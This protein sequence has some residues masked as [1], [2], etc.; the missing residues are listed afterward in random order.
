M[1]ECTQQHK[2]CCTEKVAIKQ[3]YCFHCV[4]FHM[5]T[6]NFVVTFFQVH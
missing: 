2:I 6:H 3:K 1:L 4:G 5:N